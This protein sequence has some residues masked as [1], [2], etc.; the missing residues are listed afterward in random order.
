M[1]NATVPPVKGYSMAGAAEPPV[2]S[3]NDPQ[4]HSRELCHMTRAQLLDLAAQHG[5][6]CRSNIRKPLLIE[7][8][9]EA[10]V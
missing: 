10:G 6:E 4:T 5:I 2:Y 8:L 7:M 3:H 9:E 1:T